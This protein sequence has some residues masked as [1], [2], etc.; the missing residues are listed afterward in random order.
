MIR[1]STL[2]Q[3]WQKKTK[4][5][6]NPTKPGFFK[7]PRFIMCCFKIWVFQATNICIQF[8]AHFYILWR[9]CCW[10][11]YIYNQYNMNENKIAI[12]H[13]T[14]SVDCIYKP[15]Y[16]MWSF[17]WQDSS[18]SLTTWKVPNF[19][20]CCS[21]NEHTHVS[22]SWLAHSQ[23]KNIHHIWKQTVHRYVHW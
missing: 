4:S 21:A 13:K 2:G 15:G 17:W 6:T 23:V 10:R 12:R 22:T 19:L 3:G 1:L 16:A 5:W 18:L 9:W 14:I 11:C 8:F 20:D 7:K